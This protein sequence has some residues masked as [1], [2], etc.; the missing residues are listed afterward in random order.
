MLRRMQRGSLLSLPNAISL[1]RLVLAAGFV[2]VP[3]TGARVALIGAASATDVLDGWL[4]RRSGAVS[5]WGALIDPLADRAFV[6]TA[7]TS[8]VWL[9]Q[10]TVGQYFTFLARDIATAV[11]FAVAQLV[12][13]L[14]AVEFQ[15]RLLGKVVTAL[16]LATL[17]AVLLLPSA[18]GALVLAVGVLAAV[19]IVD[20]TVSLWRARAR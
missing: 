11:G 10:L 9:G 14:R 7:V 16:Q 1:S 3:E 5:R 19:S 17:V 15:A 4:A 6:L 18:V 8:Y 13:R 20:Y 12:P 2:A